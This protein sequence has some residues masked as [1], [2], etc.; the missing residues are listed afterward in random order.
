[1]IL[2]ADV[3]AT[4]A[5]LGLFEFA[6]QRLTPTVVSKYQNRDYKSFDAILDAFLG[7]TPKVTSACFGIAGPVL[8]GKVHLTNLNWII[9]QRECESRL[10]TN[11]TLLNDMEATGYG[12]SQLRPG[13]LLTLNPGVPDENASAALIAAGT[14][15]GESALQCNGR[16]RIPVPAEA[17]HA[18]FA[19]NNDLESEL[20]MYLRKRFGHVSWDRV[21]SGPGLHLI[22]EFLRDTGR[23]VENSE[24]AK[25]IRTGDPGAVISQAALEN[26]CELCVRALNIFASIYGSESGNMALR[27]LAR[28][29][30]YLGGGIAPKIR[31][32]L[33]DGNFMKAFAAKGRMKAM[34]ELVPVYVILNDQ[35]ALLGAAH[36]AAKKLE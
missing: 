14:G 36:Y 1:M 4:N 29:G 17:G 21:L 2:A 19:P 28:A 8:E 11:V 18:D 35:A 27:Y 26:E 13:D 3:G 30:V 15:L 31:T 33:T 22:Y 23:G 34:L 7:T 6:K 12:I 16:G 20:L 32:K 25:K 24:V 10:G 5:R 9:D